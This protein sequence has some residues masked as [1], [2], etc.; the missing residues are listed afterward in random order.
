M[1]AYYFTILW[2]FLPYIDMNQPQVYMCP[3]SQTP[4]LPPFPSHPSGLSQCTSF[5]CPVSCISLD[6]WSISHMVIYMFQCYS[7][8]SSHP[9]LLFI[10]FN[11]SIIALQHCVSF[12]CITWISYMSIYIPFFLSSLPLPH[13]TTLDYHRAVSEAPC[14]I[15]QL[16]ISYL[17]VSATLSI[18]LWRTDLWFLWFYIYLP[19]VCNLLKEPRTTCWGRLLTFRHSLL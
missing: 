13:P 11:W 4:L 16:P 18:L 19:T 9:L 17:Y 6:W 3:P 1:E 10:F 5:E 8:K 12:C 7:L 14:A 15:Q 2:W